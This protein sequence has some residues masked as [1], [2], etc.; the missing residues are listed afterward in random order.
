MELVSY[1]DKLGSSRL[2]SLA[3]N[4]VWMQPVYRVI[5]KEVYTFKNLFYKYY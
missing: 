1:T 4:T 2:S 5:Q 3:H